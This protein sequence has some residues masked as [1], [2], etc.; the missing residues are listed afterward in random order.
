[1]TPVKMKTFREEKK[2]SKAE[3]ARRASMQANMI[4]W[5]ECGR[6]VPFDSQLE[7]IA[8]ALDVDDPAELMKP[9]KPEEVADHE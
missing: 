7:K 5:I 4:G 3:L 8:R 2:L 6:F 1:M 9:L